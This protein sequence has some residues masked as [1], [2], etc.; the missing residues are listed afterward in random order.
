MLGADGFIGRFLVSELESHSFSVQ[1]VSRRKVGFDLLD[2][3]RFSDWI[4]AH[5]PEVIVNCAGQTH[6]DGSAMRAANVEVVQTLLAALEISASSP[7]LIH[8]GSASEYGEPTTLPVSEEHPC[9]PCTEYGRQKWEATDLILSSGLSSCVV[10]PTNVV[11]P[12]MS[13]LSLVGG[14]LLR[15]QA[16]DHLVNNLQ[17][18]RDFVDVRELCEAVR[19]LLGVS[20]LPP[21]LNVGTGIGVDLNGVS[22]AFSDLGIQVRFQD[23]D[24]SNRAREASTFVADIRL[25][26]S[27]VGWGPSLT[28]R[29]SIAHILESEKVRS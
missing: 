2:K 21:V 22:G 16:L 27:L 17:V 11:G 19:R 20:V 8:F 26:R 5:S 6:G 23:R 7:L 9:V 12:G 24:P 15:R 28:L 18:V 29:E 25:L 13:A 3:V 14:I 1:P 10:R 4:S